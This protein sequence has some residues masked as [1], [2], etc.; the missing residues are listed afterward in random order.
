MRRKSGYMFTNKKH[1]QRG[2]LSSVLGA[3]SLVSIVLAIV[4]SYKAK[5]A[6]NA[7]YGLA[8]LFAFCIAI[9]GLVQGVRAK[10]EKDVF[11]LFPVFG[12][13]SNTLVILMGM[14]ILYSGVYGL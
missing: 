12:I 13:V 1:S 9:G 4:L 10:M 5:G 14:F 3:I 6:M 8:T 2:M 11:L 7:R